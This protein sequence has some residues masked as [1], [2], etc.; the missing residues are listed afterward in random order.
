MNL[1]VLETS[2]LI[3]NPLFVVS[4]LLTFVVLLAWPLID[5]LRQ[6]RFVWAVAIVLLAPFGGVAWLLWGLWR[7]SG[8]RSAAH[9]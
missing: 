1:I 5:S 9:A 4:A 7:L 2:Y 8:Q 6:R 3:P